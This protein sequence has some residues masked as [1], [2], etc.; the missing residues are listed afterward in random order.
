M[1]PL[2][3]LNLGVGVAASARRWVGSGVLPV[4]VS[5]SSRPGLRGAGRGEREG[6][7]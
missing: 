1:L 5:R 7:R 6:A 4:G 3:L 2:G